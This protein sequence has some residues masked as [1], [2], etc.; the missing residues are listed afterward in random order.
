MKPKYY[1]QYNGETFEIQ[2]LWATQKDGIESSI[3]ETKAITLQNNKSTTA[4][5]LKAIG[6][7]ANKVVSLAISGNGGAKATKS[8]YDLVSAY[9]SGMSEKTTVTNVKINYTIAAHTTVSFI[10]VKNCSKSDSSEL[11]SFV[12]TKCETAIN[13]S[14]PSFT[15]NNGTT[16]PKVINCS[17]SVSATPNGF[18]SWLNA[19]KYYTLTG[20]G[21]RSAYVG[22]LEI[23]GL[24]GKYLTTVSTFCPSYPAQ[25]K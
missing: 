23:Y 19:V 21:A 1:K 4:G 20:D 11:M 2:E 17:S 7:V 8:I 18:N 22:G 24:D 9:I 6:V 13:A 3:C 5:A 12:S 15:Y 16:H 10:F 14:I 25:V